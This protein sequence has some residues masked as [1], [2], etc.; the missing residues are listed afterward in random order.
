MKS[1]DELSLRLEEIIK[2]ISHVPTRY[3]FCEFSAE[4]FSE[5]DRLN[6]KIK[7]RSNVR[8]ECRA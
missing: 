3:I 6:R 5:I 4:M 2:S 8:F 7:R 1:Y